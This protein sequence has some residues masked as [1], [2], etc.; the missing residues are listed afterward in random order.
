VVGVVELFGLEEVLVPLEVVLVL[1]LQR[2][3]ALEEALG[4]VAFGQVVQQAHERTEHAHQFRPEFLHFLV[5]LS[6]LVLDVGV[7]QLHD[8]FGQAHSAFAEELL[9]FLVG[10]ACPQFGERL[11]LLD[12]VVLGAVRYS[13]SDQSLQLGLQFEIAVHLL[14]LVFEVGYIKLVQL[15][16]RLELC[17]NVE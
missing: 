5:P 16:D 11:F 17:L 10:H 1:D 15:F 7:F 6:Q 8:V 3:A 13:L 14:L 12:H 2:L 4:E 9:E